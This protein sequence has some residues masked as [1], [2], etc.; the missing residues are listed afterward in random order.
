MIDGVKIRQLRQIP[1]E[2]GMIMRFL[3]ADDPDF[4]EFGEVYFSVVYPGVVKGWH[5]HKVMTMNYTV[6]VGTVKLVLFDDR[7]GSLTRG[8]VM[9]LFVGEGNYVRVQIPPGIWNGF[10][11]VGTASAMVCNCA[12]HPHDPSDSERMPPT[13]ARIPY[14]WE[15][16]QW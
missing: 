13:D 1:D 14:C 5:L 9:E 6:P 11:G 3:R 8:E 12:S 10:K 16:V 7:E 2:R 15:L 4:T